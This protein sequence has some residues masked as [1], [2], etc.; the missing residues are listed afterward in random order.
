MFYLRHICDFGE[1]QSRF[2]S[3]YVTGGCGFIR[4]MFTAESGGEGSVIDEDS[5]L[6][7]IKSCQKLLNHQSRFRHSDTFMERVYYAGCELDFFGSCPG[8]DRH[9]VSLW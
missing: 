3:D 7:R 1:A 4:M 2:Q 8:Q 5:D 9:R 6:E